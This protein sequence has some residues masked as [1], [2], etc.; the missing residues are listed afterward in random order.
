MNLEKFKPWNWFR[1]QSSNRIP[2]NNSVGDIKDDDKGALTSTKALPSPFQHMLQMQRQFDEFFDQLWRYVGGDWPN[3]PDVGRH[4]LETSRPE[5]VSGMNAQGSRDEYRFDVALPGFAEGDVAIELTGK[6]LAINAEK[7]LSQSSA[8]KN[9]SA[10]YRKSRYSKF[11]SLP[12]DADTDSIQATMENGLLT[13]CVAK[14]V[15]SPAAAKRI[16]ITC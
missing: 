4:M 16:T 7:N 11:V 1:K 6:Q 13:V 5:F 9:G 3:T 8:S 14:K 12:E 15:S 2:L 10:F